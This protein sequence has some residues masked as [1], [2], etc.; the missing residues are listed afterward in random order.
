MNQLLSLHLTRHYHPLISKTYKLSIFR[1]I[2][3]SYLWISEFGVDGEA[4]VPAAPDLGAALAVPGHANPFAVVVVR[5]KVHAQCDDSHL[6]REGGE[7]AA[8][9]AVESQAV[10][11]TAGCQVEL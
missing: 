5:D 2:V 9:E 8:A 1:R 11:C 3:E 4:S 10:V 6:G 7:E